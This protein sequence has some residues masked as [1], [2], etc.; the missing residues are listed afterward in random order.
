VFDPTWVNAAQ[1]SFTNDFGKGR[2]K[3]VFLFVAVDK[4]DD[5]AGR[6]AQ[7]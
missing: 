2:P 4:T 3:A 1:V 5:R 7:H 6:L